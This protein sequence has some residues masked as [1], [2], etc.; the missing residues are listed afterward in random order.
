MNAMCQSKAG[1]WLTYVDK[2]AQTLD[3][4]RQKLAQR[5]FSATVVRA[6]ESVTGK[7]NAVYPTWAALLQ[8][9]NPRLRRSNVRRT[10]S[11]WLSP[12]LM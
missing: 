5:D 4:L 2:S 8:Q 1:V 3:A 10:F 6:G 12:S 7:T 11:S 9:D